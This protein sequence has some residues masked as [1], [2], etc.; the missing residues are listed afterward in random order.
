MFIPTHKPLDARRFFAR[1]AV[2]AL[3]GCMLIGA[4]FIF[5]ACSTAPQVGD[6]P[7]DNGSQSATAD[8]V[9]TLVQAN[10]C[11]T[12]NQKA[13]GLPNGA[14]VLLRGADAPVYTDAPALVSGA[15]DAAL[16]E[17]ELPK[18]VQAVYAFC[19]KVA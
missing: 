8:A 19:L 14:I 1:K 11:W 4:A 16:G 9:T 17:R 10:N 12:A 2:E 5:M 6:V 18:R 7:Q 3:L 15:F 13:K